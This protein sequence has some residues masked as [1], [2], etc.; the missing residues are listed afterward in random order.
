MVSGMSGLVEVSLVLEAN[1]AGVVVECL[2]WE[3]ETSLP[4]DPD[5]TM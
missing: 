3:C 2:S 5:T 4:P 1:G